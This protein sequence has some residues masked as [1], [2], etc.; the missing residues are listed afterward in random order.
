MTKVLAAGG[1]SGDGLQPK[2]RLVRGAIQ[3]LG[4]VLASEPYTLNPKP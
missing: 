2:L 4:Q 3:I 1:G